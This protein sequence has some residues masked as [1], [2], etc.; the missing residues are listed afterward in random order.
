V[1]NGEEPYPDAWRYREAARKNLA[2]PIPGAH[3]SKT[4]GTMC[5]AG[6]VKSGTFAIAIYTDTSADYRG[7]K[8]M[9]LA[10]VIK[11]IETQLRCKII[12]EILPQT[13]TTTYVNQKKVKRLTPWVLEMRTT[14]KWGYHWL[15]DYAGPNCPTDQV[16]PHI[17]GHTSTM[18]DTMNLVRLPH[19]SQVDAK[20]KKKEII[21]A[22]TLALPAPQ[23]KV[24]Q[25]GQKSGEMAREV[26][27]NAPHAMYITGLHLNCLPG[28][29]LQEI[30]PR[31]IT[32]TDKAML[33]IPELRRP[34]AYM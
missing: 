27:K 32:R 17:R 10:S 16:D 18:T 34:P 20:G 21:Q 23:G 26:A 25:H 3:P 15:H 4:V 6:Q 11:A 33:T 2:L 14:D 7:A 22:F 29:F 19:P 30:T 1:T 8:P 5:T 24:A 9:F 28:K 12:S 13:D 31:V